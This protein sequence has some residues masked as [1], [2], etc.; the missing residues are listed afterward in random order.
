MRSTEEPNFVHE[1]SDSMTV[2]G[3]GAEVVPGWRRREFVRTALF[4]AGGLPFFLPTEGWSFFSRSR[5][6]SPSG[7]G[8]SFRSGRIEV[9]QEW[10]RVLGPQVVEY[11]DF[12]R[13]LNLRKIRVEQIIA[14]HLKKRGSVQNTIPPKRLWRAIRPTLLAADAVARRMDE[15]VREIISA[16]RS[17]AYNARCPGA[18][19]NSYHVQNMALDLQFASSPRTVARVA[20]EL[21][22]R[23]LFQGGVGRY[24][25]FT[26]I[27]TRGRKA[28]W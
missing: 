10:V 15:P 16:Y 8:S 12:L 27:D 18:R 5:A 28:D 22:E 14:P 24:S 1:S 26:H 20:R 4:L 25:S 7:G 9:P 21:R 11:C 17:P 19:S 3:I 13:R 6:A 23:G 2:S